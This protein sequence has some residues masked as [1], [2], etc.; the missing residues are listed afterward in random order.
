MLMGPIQ[1]QG[2][3]VMLDQPLRIL[4]SVANLILLSGPRIKDKH[5]ELLEKSKFFLTLSFTLTTYTVIFLPSF[6][7]QCNFRVSSQMFLRGID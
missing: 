4:S 6:L 5:Y 1:W 7:Y 2:Q 3:S